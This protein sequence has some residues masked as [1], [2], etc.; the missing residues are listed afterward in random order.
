MCS[1]NPRAFLPLLLAQLTGLFVSALTIQAAP[2]AEFTREELEYINEQWPEARVN[3]SGLRYV[4]LEEGEGDRPRPRQRLTVLYKGSL[5]D[6][7]EFSAKQDPNDPFVFR[8]GAGEVIMGWEEAFAE[9]RPGEKRLLIIPFALA[10][11]LRGNPPKIPNRATLVFEVQL[12]S[13]E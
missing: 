7:T 11:G 3:P 2:R 1:R 6:G 12:L 13:I 10:Y 4:V 9:M 8:L 5:L